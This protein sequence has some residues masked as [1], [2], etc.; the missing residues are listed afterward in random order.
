MRQRRDAGDQAALR[1]VRVYV[2]GSQPS[3]ARRER[4]S[5]IV[6]GEGRNQ[7]EQLVTKDSLGCAREHLHLRVERVEMRE[8]SCGCGA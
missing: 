8:L 3:H 6:Q 2:V 4:C 1:H 5:G 7:A